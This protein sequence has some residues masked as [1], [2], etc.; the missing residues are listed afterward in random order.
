[1]SILRVLGCIQMT[2]HCSAYIA[3]SL[4]GFIARKDGNLDWLTD[5][6]K[7]SEDYGYA[8]YMSSI[9]V[10]VMGRNTFEKALTF[11]SWPYAGRQIVILSTTLTVENIP[12]AITGSVEIH[13][14]PLPELL[15]YL[16]SLGARRV[17]VDGGKVIQSFLAAGLI[18]EVTI[19]RVPVLIGDGI[20]LFADPGRS[21]RLQHLRTK[22]FDNGLVQSTY[23]VKRDWP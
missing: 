15:N 16:G 22:A 2:I 13:P 23:R 4:D 8:S 21:I 6:S 12:K 20:P 17:Y 3:T 5:P 11:E 14:G 1:M 19:T 18:D 7:P 9:D 10:L